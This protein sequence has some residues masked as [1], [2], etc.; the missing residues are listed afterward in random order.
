METWKNLPLFGSHFIQICIPFKIA[1]G[2][3]VAEWLRYENFKPLAPHRSGFESRQDFGFFLV[4]K[5]S[6]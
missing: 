4:R 3:S 5:L 1:H 6:T 2:A